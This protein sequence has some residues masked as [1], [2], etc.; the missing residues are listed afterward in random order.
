MNPPPAAAAPKLFDG[1]SSLLKSVLLHPNVFWLQSLF[2]LGYLAQLELLLH[3]PTASAAASYQRWA[4]S[5]LQLTEGLLLAL[6]EGAFLFP[7]C[8]AVCWRC[9]CGWGSSRADIQQDQPRATPVSLLDVVTVSVMS[10]VFSSGLT[11]TLLQAACAVAGMGLS[12]CLVC[13]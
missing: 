7:P 2:L 12:P 11:V 4:Q 10:P 8:V 3:P 13:G 9:W 1:Q 6:V 5:R